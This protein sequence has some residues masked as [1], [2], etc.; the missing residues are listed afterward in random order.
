MNFS[1]AVESLKEGKKVT[2]SSWRDGIYLMIVQ[3]KLK[4]FQPMWVA[5][6]YENEILL[7]DGWLLEGRDEEFTFCDLIPY[8]QR[9]EKAQCKDW[10]AMFIYYDNTSKILC[11]QTIEETKFTLEFDSFVATD[12]MAIE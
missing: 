10:G 7:S 3:K 6:L 2:R 9:G 4:S 11:N 12:W 1:E 5:F 8:L